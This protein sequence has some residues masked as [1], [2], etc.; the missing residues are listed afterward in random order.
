MMHASSQNCEG[1]PRFAMNTPVNL[2]Q[3]MRF[4]NWDKATWV[5]KSIIQALGGRPF[6]YKIKG[7]RKRYS[8][9]RNKYTKKIL[10]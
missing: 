8:P 2:K 9:D 6:E 3:P 1:G 7:E 4:D 10:K 5:E